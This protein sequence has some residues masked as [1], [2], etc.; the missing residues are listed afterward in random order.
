MLHRISRSLA[1]RAGASLTLSALCLYGI[2][3]ISGPILAAETRPVPPA[4][5]PPT[6][7]YARL[8]DLVL[9]SPAIARAKVTSAVAL[10]PEQAPGLN[11][12]QARFYVEAETGGLIRGDSVIARKIA[13]VM[14]GSAA[15]AKKPGLKGRTMLLF[16]RVGSP[17]NFLQL[18]SSTA[19]IDW[20]PA[21]EAL[22]RKVLADALAP[23]LP[24]AIKRIS[25][26]F[27][28]PG[29]IVGESETQIFLETTSG[30]PI[31]LSIIRRPDEQ[32]HF[33]ASLGEIVDDAA[34]LPPPGTMLWYR[35]ACG[36]PETLPDRALRS[37]D[38]ADAQA[39]ASDYAAFRQALAP[40]D[41]AATP[42]I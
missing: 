8:A 19:L 35:L 21:N 30:A 24:P 14:D 34:T 37:L 20:S 15:K 33:S 36:L 17:V 4:P 23:D 41:K 1:P 29:S 2:L 28:V 25:S 31:S 16:G 10:K 32:P 39:A 5:A 11:P 42:V 7:T 13:F 9:S 6:V 38:P 3:G 26:A 40:C 12:G 22:V 27:H 18:T